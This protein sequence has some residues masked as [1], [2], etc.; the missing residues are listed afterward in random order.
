MNRVSLGLLML[1]VGGTA[2]AQQT[3]PAATTTFGGFIDLYAAYNANSP[4]AHESFF[5]GVGSS[6]KKANELGLNLAAFTVS[7]APDPL[8]FDL[9]LNAGTA[10]DVVH[11]GEPEGRDLYRAVYQASISYQTRLGRGLLVQG[12]VFPCHAGFEGFFT[13]DNWNYTRSW[14]SELSPY[15]SAGVKLAYPFGDRWSGQLHVVNGWQTIGDV[16]D[17]KTIGTQI[18]YAGDR[19]SASFNTMHGPELADD[20][21]SMRSLAD[22]VVVYEL[23]PQLSIGGAIDKG[24]QE[25]PGGPAAD[26]LGWGAYGRY[27][28][29]EKSAVALRVERFDDDEG[30]ISGTPQTLR[31]ATVT[32]EHRPRPD[33]I[34]KLAAR[35]DDSTAPV[36]DREQGKSDGQRLLLL[37][38]VATF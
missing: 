16:N 14:L 28:W 18:A 30:G 9:V 35:A 17:G 5:S 7:R 11:G 20:N 6:A 34:L 2:A 22:L 25:Q 23:T 38:A 32:L 15:Y 12:G 31:E 24:R 13:K 33:L 37:G 3:T 36:F 21:S 4:A 26:W 8:G 1:A 27:A 19:L 10:T 29:S